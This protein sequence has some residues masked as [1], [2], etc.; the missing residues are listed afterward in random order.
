MAP[1]GFLYEDDV[2]DTF[3]F[4][5]QQFNP[6]VFFIH[7]LGVN[8]QSSKLII[9]CIT[10]ETFSEMQLVFLPTRGGGG[11]PGLEKKDLVNSSLTFCS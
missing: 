6:L 2:G 11:E 3:M 9:S 1:Q 7:I 5:Q 8:T 10:Y 4:T